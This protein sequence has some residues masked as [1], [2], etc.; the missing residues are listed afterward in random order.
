VPSYST[1]E[2]GNIGYGCLAPEASDDIHLL[3][4][5]HAVIQV[6]PDAIDGPLPGGALLVTSLR[7]VSPLVLLN[8]SLG[9]RATMT[10]RACGCPMERLGWMTHL[11]TVR[12]FEKLK[13]GGMTFLD[14]DVI[15]IL[16]E[17]LPARFGGAPTDYQLVEDE[18][19]DGR[20][21]LRLFVHPS[22]GPIDRDAVAGAFLAALGAGSGAERVMARLWQEGCFVGAERAAPRTTVVGKI[23]HLHREPGR[24][25]PPRPR[26]AR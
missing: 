2:A 8:V 19:E 16:E 9:D 14:T 22:V 18:T 11:H 5:L 1:I 26:V 3:D 12:S 20:P 25:S 13:A 4:D 6:E 17:T 21:R 10:R 7:P 23:H 15:R 24:S